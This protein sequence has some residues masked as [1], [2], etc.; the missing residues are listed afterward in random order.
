MSNKE[1]PQ[2]ERGISQLNLEDLPDSLVGLDFY[3]QSVRDAA[4]S[5]L[6][7]ASN[8]VSSYVEVEF[9]TN[10]NALDGE[11]TSASPKTDKA[12]QNRASSSRTIKPAKKR[13]RRDSE[14]SKRPSTPPARD[15]LDRHPSHAIDLHQ[16]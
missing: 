12:A 16:D 6:E 15:L 3:E 7:I 2:L 11:G 8:S 5:A 1:D 14:G 13:V 9:N 10:S 4:N